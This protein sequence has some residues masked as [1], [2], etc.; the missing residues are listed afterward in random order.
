MA[1]KITLGK[2]GDT[3]IIGKRWLKKKIPKINRTSKALHKESCPGAIY[4]IGFHYIPDEPEKQQHLWVCM[5]TGQIFK[6]T[7]K[8]VPYAKP[9]PKK[10]EPKPVVKEKKEVPPVIKK[11]K[12]VPKVEPIPEPEPE[13]LPTE[14]VA[15]AAT[16]S[17]SVEEVKGIGKAAFEKL[18]ESNITT[19]GD[20]LSRHSQEIATLIGRKSDAQIKKWQENAKSMLE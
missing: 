1:W 12:P 18:S 10:V 5:E 9:K 3:Y 8:L 6:K 11:P 7:P 4:D 14:P 2:P 19:I 16:K 15:P 17:T 13:V 20:L